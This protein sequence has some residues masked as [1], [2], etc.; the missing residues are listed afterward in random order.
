LNPRSIPFILLLAGLFGTTL[1]ASRF[2]VEQFHPT[3]FVGLR[4]SLAGLGYLGIYAF[5]VG[6]RKWP[7]N[8]WVWR[9]GALLGVFDTAL[10]MSF[11]ILSLRYQSSGLA[12]ILM[13]T[14]PAITVLLAHIFLP[15][16]PLTRRK[17]TGVGLALTGTLLLALLG[18]SG[19]ANVQ[20]A[21][22]LGYVLV[23]AAVVAGGTMTIYTRRFMRECDTIDVTA[24]R[25]LTAAMAVMPLSIFLVGF[26]LRKVT[27]QGY[28]VLGYAALAGTFLAFLLLFYN[29]KRFGA[30]AAAMTL[31]VI[32]IIAALG[33]VLALR[34]T[35][36]PGMIGGMALIMAGV[37]ILDRRGTAGLPAGT[38]PEQMD[39]RH[40]H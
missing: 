25:M 17:A 30:T 39:K 36:T 12:S 7:T 20:R 38:Y 24:V 40:E 29:I 21:N 1:V 33:G 28:L 18:E 34:E 11:I 14:G 3:T 15:D 10:P 16:E 37:A 5:S 23:M 2:G 13:A 31:Y 22:P 8:H 19:L 9:H 26:D 35:I 32:P 27:W 4:L 6:G